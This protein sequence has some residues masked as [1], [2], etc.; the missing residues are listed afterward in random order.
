MTAASLSMASPAPMMPLIDRRSLLE[1]GGGFLA[2]ATLAT[3]PGLVIAR[4][5]SQQGLDVAAPEELPLMLASF[6]P[7]VGSAFLAL[8][9]EV[10]RVQLRLLEASVPPTVGST[11]QGECFGLLFEGPLSLRVPAGVWPLRHRTAGVVSLYIS[12]VGR[13]VRAQ[14]YQAVID[15]RIPSMLRTRNES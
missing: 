1:A 14:E 7:L 3:R 13:A 10:G 8:V 12:P 6:V 15:R 9:P 2:A 4:R 11:T 5:R